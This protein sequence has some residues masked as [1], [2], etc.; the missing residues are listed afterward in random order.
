MRRTCCSSTAGVFS[1]PA[2]ASASS[3]SS[4]MLLHR[5]NDSREASSTSLTRCTRARPS[6]GRIAFDA[7]D[8]LRTG[9]NQLQ[10]PLDAGLERAFLAAGP[11]EAS[12]GC[13]LR[14]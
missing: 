1:R 12:S 9:Q 10:R 8:E 7:E 14:R 11:V 6:V 2:L 4:G 3:S 13:S 5:K